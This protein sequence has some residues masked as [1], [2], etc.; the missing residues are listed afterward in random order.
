MILNNRLLIKFL[1]LSFFFTYLLW[2]SIAF[3]NCF[4][5]L[6]WGTPF[7]MLFYVSGTLAP[8]VVAFICLKQSGSIKTIK[9][10]AKITFSFRGKP[11]HYLMVFMFLAVLYVPSIILNG[12]NS[13]T[14]WYLWILVL[15]PMLLAG[16]LEEP[17]WRY[18][19]QP[20]LEKRFPFLIATAITAVIWWAWHLPL[21]L[22]DGSGQT[23]MSLIQY[24]LL[25]FGLSLSLATIFKISRNI[26]LCV[27]FHTLIN[28]LAI[29][30]SI[31]TDLTASLIS[32]V[33]I[34]VLS[35]IIMLKHKTARVRQSK[36]SS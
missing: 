4:G 31:A 16:G 9:D 28:S 2:G 1:L 22:I 17:A 12:T 8:T 15:V 6:E 11:A 5:Y 18:L 19:L 13:D 35:V 20:T 3:A 34:I 26:W 36:G 23:E 21:F 24:A 30:W 14:A 29:Y 10:F 33:G 7:S 25:I 32:L 27:M